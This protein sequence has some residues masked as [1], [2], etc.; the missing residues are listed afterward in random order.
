VKKTEASKST[1]P[2]PP[3]SL[4]DKMRELAAG[5][6]DVI[7]G[8]DEGELKRDPE[9]TFVD[10]AF[11]LILRLQSTALTITTAPTRTHQLKLDHDAAA[12]RILDIFTTWMLKN[13]GCS[14]HTRVSGSGKFQIV[15]NTLNSTRLFFG[16]TV[17]DAYAQAAQTICF[18]DT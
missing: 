1:S 7:E 4:D 10:L 3:K 11:R 14:Y 15:V 9:A 13:P 8:T 2:Q 12:A 16:E 17:Q 18:D 5:L 6:K